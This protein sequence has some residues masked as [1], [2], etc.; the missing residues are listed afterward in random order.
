[1]R[2]AALHKLE[3]VSPAGFLAEQPLLLGPLA[4]T[5]AV[6]GLAWLFASASGRRFLP[7]GVGF[8]TVLALLMAFRTVRPVYLAAAYTALVAAGGVGIESLAWRPRWAIAAVLAAGSLA[9][10]PMALPVLPVEAYV[11]Y[12][13]R[14]GV[15][16]ATDE[17]HA[18][19]AL[20]QHFAD[21]F[22][23]EELAAEVAR[24]VATLE[25]E[26]RAA[27]GIFAQNYGQ[28]GALDLFGRRLGL[29]PAMSGHNSYW[30]WGPRGAPA[31]LVVVGGNAEDNREVCGSLTAAGRTACRHCMPYENGLTIWICR[32][33]QVPI[34]ELWPRLRRFI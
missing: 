13:G 2:N 8:V 10:V 34:A 11:A 32:D 3:P 26:E 33:L 18:L 17:R 4:L 28:A 23:W 5:V 24:V 31:T 27:A 19:G 15:A 12:A 14:L 21:M 25:P 29:P 6:A 7:I 16:P 1:M 22:G 9:L 20:P 30:D